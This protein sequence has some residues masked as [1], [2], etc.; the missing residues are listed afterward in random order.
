MEGKKLLAALLVLL[1]AAPFFAK[2]QKSHKYALK[3]ANGEVMAKG[4]FKDGNEI[5][6]PVADSARP[7]PSS[8]ESD[9]GAAASTDSSLAN[10]SGAS[11]NP[12]ASTD[13]S[14]AAD[15]GASTDSGS[16]AASE[17]ADA[18]DKND[19]DNT[20]HSR[21]T[22]S[23][24]EAPGEG[25][26]Y[27][28]TKNE[29]NEFS[30]VQKL[31]WSAV[32]DIKN[33]RIT[34]QRKQDDGAWLD[35]LQKD[36][37]ENKIEVSLPAGEYRFQ[38]GVVNLFDQLEKSTEWKSL[39]VLK[40]TQP[41]IDS[42]QTDSMYLNSKKATGLFTLRGE[43]LTEKTMFTMEQRESDPPKIIYGKIVSIDSDGQ[44]AEVQFDI[45][46]INEGVYEIY[47]QNPGG[48]SVISKTI[49]IKKKKDRNWRFLASAGYTCPFTFFDGTFNNYT[50][51]CFYPLSGTGKIE[52]ISFYTKA[53]NFGF[54]LGGNFSMFSNDTEKMSLSGK[55]ANALAYL[56]WQKYLVPQKL[57]LDIHVGAGAAYMWDV[58]FTNKSYSFPIEYN[59]MK[60]AAL[61][62][63]GGLAVQYHLA[64]HF[65]LEGAVDFV[66]AKFGSMN[67]GMFYPSLSIGGMF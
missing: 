27:Y 9:S 12:A 17:N 56:V 51:N 29:N 47:A 39:T 8:Q 46:E 37:F 30:F 20:N 31:S 53:G 26:N 33:Y 11:S 54:G 15:S 44:S 23:V 34:I 41:K 40:A 18:S 49:R 21:Y 65:Y 13:S 6:I 66:N 64:K 3:G 42:M 16:E 67:L 28:I 36:L 48:L 52:V 7:A 62:F 24:I 32:K 14:P 55:Y 63:G 38:V 4:K 5:A 35:V 45:N 57:C 43:N 59:P 58:Q 10:D 2:K 50:E 19:K 61:A 22:I 25:Q 60:S 1:A